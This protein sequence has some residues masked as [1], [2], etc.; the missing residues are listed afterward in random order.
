MYEVERIAVTSKSSIEQASQ[1][2]PHK[3]F[4]AKITTWQDCNGDLKGL[5]TGLD[6]CLLCFW[7]LESTIRL[8]HKAVSVE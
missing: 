6:A 5:L 3:I 2:T 8:F 7:R 4:S 1:E